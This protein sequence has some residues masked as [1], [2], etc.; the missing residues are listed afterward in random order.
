MKPIPES[1]EQDYPLSPADPQEMPEPTY[2]PVALAFGVLFI[3]WGLISSMYISGVGLIISAI[4]IAGWII[5]LNH[6]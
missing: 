1:I 3:F 5:E 2:W 4:A 6:E